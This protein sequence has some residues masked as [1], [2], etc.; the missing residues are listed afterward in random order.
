M[1]EIKI[2][3]YKMRDWL[4]QLGSMGCFLFLFQCA[5][6]AF[7]EGDWLQG[8][9]HCLGALGWALVYLHISKEIREKNPQ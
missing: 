3:D 1:R 2:T 8:L 6:R 7:I 5:V 9:M 4:R